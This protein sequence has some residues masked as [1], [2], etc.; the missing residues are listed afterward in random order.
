M[1]TLAARSAHEAL[2]QAHKQS[3]RVPPDEQADFVQRVLGS[4]LAAASLGLKD[5]RTLSSWAKGGEIR[6]EDSRHRLQVL[7]RVVVA[8][9]GLYGPS[10]A[11]AFFRGS[12]PMLGGRS[13]LA[14]LAD[15]APTESETDLLA[16]AEVLL[17]A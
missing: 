1:T 13:P 10:V 16:A 14:V 2:E 17:T 5:T 15:E 3:V 8:I 12:N 7:Y 11:A 9:D 4:R 6:A